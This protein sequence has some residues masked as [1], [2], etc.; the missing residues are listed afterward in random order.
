MYPYSSDRSAVP[1]E[2]TQVEFQIET[3]KSISDSLFVFSQ[4]ELFIDWINNA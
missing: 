1:L 4:L 3:S 2:P